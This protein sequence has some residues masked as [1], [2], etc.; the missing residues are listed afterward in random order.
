[1]GGTRSGSSREVAAAAREQQARVRGG[2]AGSEQGRAAAVRA[3]SKGRADAVVRW[4]GEEA[5]LGISA[6]LARV[7]AAAD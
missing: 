4:L 6:S 1:V 5:V 2:S 7:R 3:A